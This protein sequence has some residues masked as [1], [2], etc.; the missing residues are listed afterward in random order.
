MAASYCALMHLSLSLSLS[1][2]LCFFPFHDGQ[3]DVGISSSMSRSTDNIEQKE[4]FIKENNNFFMYLLQ[5]PLHP[6][7]LC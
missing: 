6:I 2:S 4:G 7:F 1:L 3:T 5:S